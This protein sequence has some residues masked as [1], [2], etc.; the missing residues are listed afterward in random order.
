MFRFSL[1]TLL[2]VTA[3]AAFLAA[4]LAVGSDL[5]SR[6]AFTVTFLVIAVALAAA[7]CGNRHR[8]AWGGFALAATGYLFLALIW[9]REDLL[10]TTRLLDLMSPFPMGYPVTYASPITVYPTSPAVSVYPT[11]SIESNGSADG[12]PTPAF[13]PDTTPANSPPPDVV[14]QFVAP[15]VAPSSTSP[16]QMS[17]TLGYAPHAAGDPFATFEH[18]KRIGHCGLA[19]LFG[20]V[21]ALG[22]WFV[23]R[24]QEERKPQ[25]T[26]ETPVSPKAIS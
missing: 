21:A 10:P 12:S 9:S 26:G 2:A 22:G 23:A 7:L 25:N 20:L 18:R 13:V 24:R 5:C 4:G 17:A 8:V 11:P 6:A 19:V 16:V 1:K 3:Y 15:A 14:T